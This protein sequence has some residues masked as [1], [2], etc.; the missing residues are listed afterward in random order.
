MSNRRV[1]YPSYKRSM[2]ERC[3]DTPLSLTATI[4]AVERPDRAVPTQRVGPPRTEL[5]GLRVWPSRPGDRIVTVMAYRAHNRPY[6]SPRP[7]P[8]TFAVALTHQPQEPS[9]QA[10]STALSVSSP[11]ISRW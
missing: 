3:S 10:T 11:A 1:L 4:L 7:R 6:P 5:Y 9:W 2:I 8:S